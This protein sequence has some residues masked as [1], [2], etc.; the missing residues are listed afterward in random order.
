MAVNQDGYALQFVPED[1]R[2]DEICK[3]AVNQNGYA[4]EFVPTDKQTDEIC[5]I[6]ITQNEKAI[7]FITNKE[8]LNKLNTKVTSNCNTQTN[9]LCAICLNEL[10]NDYYKT[11]VCNHDYHTECINMMIA[12]KKYFCQICK[13]LI[14]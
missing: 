1:K 6:A 11:R 10:D 12:N 2:T 3:I 9:E 8:L 5:L 13:K 7:K 14:L 4:L